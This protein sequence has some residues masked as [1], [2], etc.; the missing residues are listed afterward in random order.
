[1]IGANGYAYCPLRRGEL[2]EFLESLEATFGAPKQRRGYRR[3]VAHLRPPGRL[4]LRHFNCAAP[5]TPSWPT[6]TTVSR[7][8]EPE[9]C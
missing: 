3:A 5:G 4:T 2:T 7:G 1:M 9:L 8:A 6:L